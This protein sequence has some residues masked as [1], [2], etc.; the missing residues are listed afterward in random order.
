MPRSTKMQTRKRK[1]TRNNKLRDKAF[2]YVE[3]SI[4]TGELKPNDR[5]TEE[6]VAGRVGASR[7]PVREALDKLERE[8]LLYRN[9]GNRLVVRPLAEKEI[10]DA[11]DARSILEGY[12][13]ALAAK[14]ISDAQIKTLEELIERQEKSLAEK[15]IEEFCRLDEQFHDRVARE[16]GNKHLFD[17]LNKLSDVMHRYRFT[18]LR[19]HSKPVVALEDH[20]SI[21]ASL[22]AR[23]DKA[24]EKAVLKHIGRGRDFLKKKIRES[25]EAPRI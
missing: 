9:E 20:K 22:K 17:L 25:R 3:N 10:G 14:S 24:V 5:V 23:D 2:R 19:L 12:A 11:F 16:A 1:S 7:T 21:L 13:A 6:E 18:I 8:E 4:L 15:D